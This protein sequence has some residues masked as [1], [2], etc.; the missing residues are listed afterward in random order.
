MANGLGKIGIWSMEMRL[1]GP[2]ELRAAGGELE[3]LGFGAIWVPGGID[4]AVLGNVTSLLDATRRT[5]IATGIINVWKQPAADVGAWWNGQSA[6]RQA[7]TMLGFGISHGPLIG[8]GYGKPLAT[9]SAYLDDLDVAG[10]PRERRCLAALGPKMLDLARERAAGA[11]PYLITAEH[12]RIARERLGPD[13]LLMPEQGVILETDPARARAIALEGV[14]NYLQLP[15]YVNSWRRLGFSE[16]DVKGSDRL[17]DAL[18]I[19]GDAD[20]IATGVKAHLDAGADHVCLQVVRGDIMQ[21][22]DLPIESWR[23]LAGILL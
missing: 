17:L 23:T 20:R 16:E 15:N 7:R 2:A 19:W 14:A 6:D 11:H 1:A 10:V 12:T 4:D 21:N 8:E 22:P 3:E 18:F 5:T 13:A 9:M